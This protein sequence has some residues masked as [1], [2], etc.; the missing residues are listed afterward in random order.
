M[1]PKID[2]GLL[3]GAVAALRRTICT[4]ADD[5]VAVR[6]VC[7]MCVSGGD[8]A[9]L[10]GVRYT[11]AGLDGSIHQTA[12]KADHE[13]QVAC[14]PASRPL[15][16]AGRARVGSGAAGRARMGSGVAGRARMGS[17]VAGRARAGPV[18]GLLC[19]A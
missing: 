14:A 6:T 7:G 17:G 19:D 9:G 5:S 3:C 1:G 15:K 10:H 2:A 8:F 16:R 18:V 4:A 12:D 11:S 13:N